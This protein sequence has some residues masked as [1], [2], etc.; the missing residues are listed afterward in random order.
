MVV[1]MRDRETETEMEDCYDWYYVGH[2]F[3]SQSSDLHHIFLNHVEIHISEPFIFVLFD[4]GVAALRLVTKTTRLVY[5]AYRFSPNNRPPYS[6]VIIWFSER[7]HIFLRFSNHV[8]HFCC[9]LFTLKH[10]Y[11]ILF[12]KSIING[13]QMSIYNI[14]IY[15]YIY[16][17]R[18]R[19]GNRFIIKMWPFV[20]SFFFFDNLLCGSRPGLLKFNIFLNILIFLLRIVPYPRFTGLN[21]VSL[22]LSLTLSLSLYIYIYIYIYIYMWVCVCVCVCVIYWHLFTLIPRCNILFSTIKGC[23]RSI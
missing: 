5:S 14:Y 22:F 16:I 17:E 12:T 6:L 21:T 11:N 7:L 8:I 18:E 13:C 2:I 10:R 19:D 3:E 20:V 9:P 23:Q 4:L 1:C 15:I